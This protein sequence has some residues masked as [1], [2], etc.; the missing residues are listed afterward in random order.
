M[1]LLRCIIFCA[2]LAQQ[3]IG[4]LAAS[5]C[6]HESTDVIM[7]T[8]NQI[9]KVSCF[10]APCPH[11]PVIPPSGSLSC[12]YIG[13]NLFF[14]FFPFTGSQQSQPVR[15]GRRSHRPLLFRDARPGSGSGQRH[16]D[17]S[18]WR[19][20]R[21]E[22]TPNNNV[23]ALLT[24][25]SLLPSLLSLDVSHQTLHQKESSVD[26]VQGVPE[27]PGVPAPGFPQA[28]GEAGGSR[29]R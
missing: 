28:Q 12:L 6:F 9:R 10:L 23:E 20:K 1:R 4:Y 13:F 27:V 22:L 16:H 11:V 2:L 5:Q 25:L 15:H 24:K 3:R 21:L 19:R 8:T 14:F 26:H 17:T 29:P 18:E 7:L